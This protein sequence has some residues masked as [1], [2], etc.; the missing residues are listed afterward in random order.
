MVEDYVKY[1]NS[2]EKR[3]TRQF[4]LV[5]EPTTQISYLQGVSCVLIGIG[6]FWKLYLGYYQTSY[7]S[8]I[9]EF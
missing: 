4:D 9:T 6:S 3:P 8:R 5:H 7:N 2:G 1:N